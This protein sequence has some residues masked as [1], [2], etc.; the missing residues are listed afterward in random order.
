MHAE[1]ALQILFLETWGPVLF[2]PQQYTRTPDSDDLFI[3]NCRKKK[4]N[5]DLFDLSADCLIVYVTTISVY[6]QQSVTASIQVSCRYGPYQFLESCVLSVKIPKL[7]NKVDR[8][9]LLSVPLGYL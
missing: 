2:D 8:C 7:L 3:R 9:H 6:V 4:L 5:T 1:R